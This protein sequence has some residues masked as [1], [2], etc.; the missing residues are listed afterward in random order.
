MLCNSLLGRRKA[1]P[2]GSLANEPSLLRE[3]QNS[4]R[5]R[6][7]KEMGRGTEEKKEGGKNT[8]H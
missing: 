2:W 1:D 4:E 7:E 5:Q 3:F 6:T 8:C